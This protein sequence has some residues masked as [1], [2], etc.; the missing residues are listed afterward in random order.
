MTGHSGD[1]LQ[2]I[3]SHLRLGPGPWHAAQ[4]LSSVK[5]PKLLGQNAVILHQDSPP[6]WRGGTDP[7]TGE[8]QKALLG[9]QAPGC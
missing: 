1:G 5:D 2:D 9:T 8:F 4:N 6:T 7:E 3:Q